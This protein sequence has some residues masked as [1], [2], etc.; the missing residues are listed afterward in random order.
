MPNWLLPPLTEPEFRDHL[1]RCE[2]LLAHN[3][4]DEN[5]DR[6]DR[7][8]CRRFLFSSQHLQP[9]VRPQAGD[10]LFIRVAHPGHVADV[11]GWHHV[12]GTNRRFSPEGRTRLG[13]QVLY[14]PT[15]HELA[16]PVPGPLDRSFRTWNTEDP[17]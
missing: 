8:D 4:Q 7:G 10:H 17:T 5:G 15:F 3:R 11:V 14:N 12:I 6:A 1:G 16:N 13:W 2:E 9:A